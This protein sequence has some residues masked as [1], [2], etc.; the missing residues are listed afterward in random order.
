MWVQRAGQNANTA[1]M[2]T[3]SSNATAISMRPNCG[4]SLVMN[5][6]ATNPPAISSPRASQLNIVASYA[7][8]VDVLSGPVVDQVSLTHAGVLFRDPLRAPY[9]KLFLHVYE[10]ISQGGGL[11]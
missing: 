8:A 2:N 11:G 4:E 3:R 7:V 1:T 6:P 10:A 9:P 5:Q